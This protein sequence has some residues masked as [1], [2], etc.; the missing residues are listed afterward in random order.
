MAGSWQ[1]SGWT[2]SD[3][4][5]GEHPVD[6]VRFQGSWIAVCDSGLILRATNGSS[7]AAVGN[8]AVDR[9]CSIA[10][11]SDRVVVVGDKGAV[12]STAKLSAWTITTIGKGKPHLTGVWQTGNDWLVSGFQFID[13]VDKGKR[14]VE[15]MYASTDTS[16][17]EAIDLPRSGAVLAAAR[18]KES[19]TILV[20]QKSLVTLGSKLERVSEY[21]LTDQSLDQGFISNVGTETSALVAGSKHSGQVRP[22]E[23]M[24]V[25]T[26]TDSVDWKL[27]STVELESE[28]E[29]PIALMHIRGEPVIVCMDGS[30]ASS[31]NGIHWVRLPGTSRLALRLA[32]A[33]IHEAEVVAVGG[34]RIVHGMLLSK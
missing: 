22:A 10:C 24:S 27:R 32:K 16:S 23:F 13:F 1:F 15:E 26:A 18:G 28:Q 20:T 25:L 2:F 4:P 6:I 14:L 19:A 11:S 17:W 9:A 33:L 8:S 29:S 21:Y 31:T 7:W 30:F 34:G 12:A 5:K 3:L